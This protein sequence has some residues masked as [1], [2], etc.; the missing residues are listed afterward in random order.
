MPPDAVKTT[1]MT[2]DDEFNN[3]SS[4]ADAGAVWTTRFP[5]GGDAAYSLPGNGELEFYSNPSVGYNPFSL[6]NGVLNITAEPGS[7]KLGLPYNSGTVNTFNSFAQTYGYFEVNAKLPSGQGLWPAF[8]MLPASNNYTAE[9]DI[10]EVIGSRP[11]V[12]NSTVHGTSNGS[13]YVDAQGWVGPDTSADF[14]TYGVDWEPGTTTFYLDGKE[15][16]STA[17]PQSMNSPMYMLLNLAVG[18][19]WPGS[20][21]GS[22]KFPATM[23][24]DYVRAYATA[25]TRDIG[26]SASM[27]SSSQPAAVV[28]T[29][30][31]SVAPSAAPAAAPAATAAPGPV[32][33]GSGPDTIRVGLSEDAW[34]GDAQ[35]VITVDNQTIGGAQTVTASHGAGKTQEFVLNG[36]WGSGQHSVGIQFINDAYG[37]TSATD[38]NLFVDNVS[39]NGTGGSP[40]S[41]ALS[42]SGQAVFTVGTGAAASSSGGLVLHLSEDAFNGDA[43]FSVAVDGVEQGGRQTVTASHANG[44]T[45]DFTIV[46]GLTPGPHN[47][48]ITY[49]NDAWGGTPATDRN[50][51]VDGADYKGSAIP[52]SALALTSNGAGQFSMTVP[53]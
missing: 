25:N 41:A 44:A 37:G 40:G 32:N 48:A 27:Q 22:T 35:A 42:Q 50:L 38:R 39:L 14:H 3:F 34:Q 28:T 12:V 46:S 45:Q 23:S 52:G 10:F 30:A 9:L 26:G 19:Y 49:L 4:S 36:T 1:S 6:Q 13:F 24:I 8:W 15:L 21:D 53:A 7:N 17:T 43:L 29:E 33:I 18:G 47:V 16:G 5:Y 20:P 31:A 2:F 11:N 51:Y